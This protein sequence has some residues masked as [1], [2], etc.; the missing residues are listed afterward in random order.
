MN[1]APGNAGRDSWYEDPP[2]RP[3]AGWVVLALI[4]VAVVFI[5][6]ALAV[7]GWPRQQNTAGLQPA[8]TRQQDTAALQPAATPQQDTAGLQP[9]PT[10]HQDTAGF[11]PT[12]IGRAHV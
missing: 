4:S 10:R 1:G 2:R 12:E 6:G 11:H 8:A 5:A 9:A 3:R 7:K